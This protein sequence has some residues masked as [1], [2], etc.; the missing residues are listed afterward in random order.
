MTCLVEVKLQL[1]AAVV[2]GAATE[3]HVAI[4]V[5]LDLM[6][7]NW[8]VRWHEIRMNH[9]A[10]QTQVRWGFLSRWPFAPP[11]LR[12]LCQPRIRCSG[13]FRDRQMRASVPRFAVDAWDASVRC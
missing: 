1:Q 3:T 4:N 11:T 6:S 12:Q 2:V 5:L 9:A 13:V 7:G 8:L 10:A